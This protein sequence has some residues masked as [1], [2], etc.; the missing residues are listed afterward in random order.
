HLPQTRQAALEVALKQNPDLDEARANERATSYAV[1]DAVGALLPQVAVSGQ[2]QYLLN[3]PN[4]SIFGISGPQQVMGVTA[5]VNIPIYQGGAEEATVR[6]A[7]DV[8]DQAGMALVSAERGVRQ[9]LD[10]AWD[11]LTAAQAAIVADESQNKADQ[12]AVGGVK[13]EQ[14]AGERSVL[15][16]LNAQQELFVAEVELA[17]SDH[18]RVVAAYRLLAAMGQLTARAQALSVP[19]YDPEAHYN[20]NAHAWFGFDK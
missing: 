9:S 18:D 8:H 1:D 7:K 17:A 6:R 12:N 4:Q 19:L 3:A 2:Y 14:E 11:A 5:E 13:Q 20:D 15:D 10:S 16:I